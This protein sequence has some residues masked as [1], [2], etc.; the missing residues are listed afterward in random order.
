MDV[1]QQFGSIVRT[2]RTKKGWTQ[3]ELAD[4]AGLDTDTIGLYERGRRQPLIETV[5]KL[6]IALKLAP[7]SLVIL[8]RENLDL[9]E[10]KKNMNI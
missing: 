5:V 6:E 4:R 3:A 1:A 10:M 2:E 7:G 8:L 9:D